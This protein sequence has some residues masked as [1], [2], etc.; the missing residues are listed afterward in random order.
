M[1]L[2]DDALE[3]HH[4]LQLK[5]DH[6]IHAGSATSRIVVLDQVTHERQIEHTL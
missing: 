6:G 4:Q 2:A 5:E 1:P 3:K